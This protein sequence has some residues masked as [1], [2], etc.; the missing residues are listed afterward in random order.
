MFVPSLNSQGGSNNAHTNGKPRYTK[1]LMS[2]LQ[3]HFS[4][5]SQHNQ[6]GLYRL[7]NAAVDLYPH[8]LNT[9]VLKR[10]QKAQQQ[11]ISRQ[12][13][14]LNKNAYIHL[15]SRPF[16]IVVMLHVKDIVLNVQFLFL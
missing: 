9:M 3:V 8:A 7:V 15:L 5:I 11:E 12:H 4:P 13:V 16:L 6:A 10:T 2:T 14:T 1:L